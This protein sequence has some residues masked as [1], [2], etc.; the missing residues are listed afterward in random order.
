MT[1][2]RSGTVQAVAD[3]RSVAMTASGLR[4]V[5]G[6][7]VALERA[8]IGLV[9]G[10]VHALLGENGAGKSTLVRILT[11]AVRAD[12]GQIALNGATYAPGSLLEARALGVATA[13]Q[14]LSLVP[15]LSVAQNLLLPNLPRG[16]VG[17]VSTRRVQDMGAA[18]LARHGLQR[19]DPMAQV[20]LLPLAERQ[21][22]EIVRAIENAASV[23]ILDEPTAALAETDWLFDRTNMATAKGVAVVYTSHRLAEVRQSCTEATVLRN[24]SS[25]ASVSL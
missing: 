12:A 7:T 17:L 21:R 22:I 18:I 6:A 23:L 2:A 3:T 15:N 25:I 4:K 20:G 19:I 1:D 13:F 9:A 11:G 14:E 8:D 10:G 5:Y 24:G 16:P